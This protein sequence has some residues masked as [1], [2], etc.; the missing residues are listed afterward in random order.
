LLPTGK[1]LRKATSET[2]GIMVNPAGNTSIVQLDTCQQFDEGNKEDTNRKHENS[3]AF[4]NMQN[5][6]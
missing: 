2:E 3:Q 6:M 5:I 4:I 1:Q